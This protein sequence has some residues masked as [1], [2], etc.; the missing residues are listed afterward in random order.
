MD[1]AI[2]GPGRIGSTFAFHLSRAGHAVTMIARGP[3]LEQLR[4]DGAIVAVNAD[5]APVQVAS[6]LDRKT[7]YDLVL[8]TVLA[9]QVDALLPELKACAAK[10]VLFMYNSFDPLDRLRDAVGAERFAAGF[11]NMAAFFVEGRLKS[12]VN[13]PG[14]VTT[15]SSPTWAELLE[16]AGMPTEVEADMGSY[17]RSHVAFVVPLM[18]A[19]ILTWQRSTELTWAEAKKLTA[20]L[21]EALALV[22]GLG[23]LLKPGFVAVLGG[24]P[25]FLLTAILWAFARTAANKNLGEF[26]PAE[27]CALIDAMTKA[28]PGRTAKLLAIRP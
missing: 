22:R 12:N 3:R 21:V 26:G 15:L 6:A 28:A 13:G 27:P 2:I 7:P 17:L 5:R 18:A 14:M 11:P 16:Q 1:I 19:A 23:H 24:L 4:A 20:A 8:V 25:S 10:T 9:H